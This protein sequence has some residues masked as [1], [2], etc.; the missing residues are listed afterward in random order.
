MIDAQKSDFSEK[1]DFLTVKSALTQHEGEISERSSQMRA[2]VLSGGGS[3]GS[4]QT[5]ALR[6]LLEQDIRP[7]MIVGCS[8]GSLNASYF[9][10]EIS[11]ENVDRLADVWRAVTTRDV[12]PGP[13]LKA[14]WRLLSGKDSLFDNHRFYEFLQQHGISPA[15]TFAE[16]GQAVQLYITAT[17]LRSGTLHVFGD[18]PNDRVLDALMASTA[19]TPMHPPWTVDGERYVDGGAVTP[20]PLRVAL[21][22]G[23]DEIYA[24]H[25]MEDVE[26]RSPDQI[27][28]G[29]GGVLSRTLSAMFHLQTQH[30]LL[31]AE[32]AKKVVVHDIE[33]R[34]GNPPEP[35]DFSQ[36]ERLITL[37]YEQTQ[38]Y[39]AALPSRRRKQRRHRRTIWRRPG[40]VFRRGWM[41]RE[42]V[43]APQPVVRGE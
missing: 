37:G 4:S 30:D 2:F 19:L 21:E 18:N 38:A 32:M 12:Y 15:T 7:D 40:G 41:G 36:S 35:T 28:R 39:L 27:V 6:A 22:R 16:I 20:L 26:M 23:A 34:I 24:L 10:R 42:P 17:H 25:I 8:A 29:V 43:L 13:K 3:L 1:S 11:L 9:A 5:G 33:L 14:L 31:L